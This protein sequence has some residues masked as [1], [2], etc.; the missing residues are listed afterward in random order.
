VFEDVPTRTDA[1][2]TAL[3]C[4]DAAL[5]AALPETVVPARVSLSG[6]VLTVGDETVDLDAFDRVVVLGG[7]KA[8]GGVVDELESILGDRITGGAVVVPAEE[9]TNAGDRRVERL[10]GDHPV[11]SEPGVES[12]R[13]VADLAADA[14]AE[15]LVLAVVTGGASALLP[16]PADDV[17]LTA[18]RETTDALLA[19]G[20]SIDELNA[21]RKHLSTL[22]GGGLAALAQPATVVSVLISDVVGDDPSVVGSGPTAP[23]DSTYD[24]AL[25]VLDRYGVS[26]PAAVRD[27]LRRGAAGDLPETPVA[28]DPAFDRVRTVLLANGFRSLAAA[29]E[30]ARERGYETCLLS[31][32]VRGEAREVGRTHAAVAEEVVA[33]GNPVEPPAVVLSGGETTVTVTGDGEGGPN[34]EFAL[35]AG[36]ELAAESTPAVVASVDSDGRDGGTDVAGA[37]VDADTVVDEREARDALDRNDALG[38]L[39][40][41]AT[42]LR[43]G[44]TGTNVNDLRVVVVPEPDGTG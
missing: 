42:V 13:R 35:A 17:G 6:D 30:T 28:G 2:A 19:S 14:D 26:V 33:S 25:A 12:A 29:R 32:R 3:A 9:A 31:S 23:D 16:A 20:A 27:R 43:P 8:T 36:V 5:S 4:L 24:D 34:L 41:R 1:A 18:L 10:P 11:P 38:Y 22:K 39:D 15:T 7:G 40:G 44:A 37:L 21:V